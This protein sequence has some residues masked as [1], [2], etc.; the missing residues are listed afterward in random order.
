[1]EDAVTGHPSSHLR[2]L[3]R[4]ERQIRHLLSTKDDPRELLS[5]CCELLVEQ[6]RYQHAWIALV[7]GDGDRGAVPLYQHGFGHRTALLQKEL[8]AGRLVP[9]QRQ[10]LETRRV[11]LVKDCTQACAGCPLLAQSVGCA[12]IVAALRRGDDVYGWI[13][14]ALE[15]ELVIEQ[16]EVE[17]VGELAQTL[18]ERLARRSDH[19]EALAASEVRWRT[20]VEH[21][22]VGVIISDERGK[23]LEANETLAEMLGYTQAELAETTIADFPAEESRAAGRRH[24]EQVMRTG[25]ASG[26][27]ILRRKDGVKI[28][29][30]IRATRLPGRRVLAIF[31]D[32]SQQQEAQRILRI[33]RDLGAALAKATDL[34]QAL[35]LALRAAIES[36][37]MDGG[38]VYLL[39]QQQQCWRLAHAHG[40]AGQVA[41]RLQT[42]PLSSLPGQTMQAAQPTY[43]DAQKLVEVLPENAAERQ[44]GYRCIGTVPV[45]HGRQP[46]A[47]INVGSKSRTRFSE[48]A[49][50]S[51]DTIRGHLGSVIAR[52]KAGEALR[53]SEQMYRALIDQ[54]ADGV[55]VVDAQGDIATFNDQAYLMLGYTAEEFG[56]LSI[57]DLDAIDTPSFIRRRI[58][59]M[60]TADKPVRFETR[61]FTKSGEEREF[62]VSTRAV[63]LEQK[64]YLLCIMRDITEQKRAEAERLLLLKAIDQ[65]GEMV[66]ITDETG[67]IQYVNPAFV[68]ATGYP[69]DEVLGKN[70]RLLKSGKHD[71]AFYREL[72]ATLGRGE[73]WH[74][75]LINKRKD[76]T[77]FTEE[78]I[79]SPVRNESGELT[80][81][82]AAKHDVTKRLRLEEQVRQAQKMEAVGRLA[83]GVAHD[84]NNI[85]SII[86]G[87]ASLAMTDAALAPEQEKLLS[88]IV[89]AAERATRLTEQLLAFSRKQPTAPKV[90]QLSELVDSMRE[91]LER[92][93]GE[94]IALSTRHEATEAVVRVDSGQVEQILLNLAVNARD[95]M[96]NGGK[97]HIATDRALVEQACRT[98]DRADRRRRYRARAGQLRPA[99]CRGHGNRHGQSDAR[100]RLRALFHHQGGGARHRPRVGNRARYRRAKRR[101][102]RRR[103]DAGNRHL[104][105][106]SF[107]R[108]G[109]AAA[110]SRTHVTGRVHRCC[111]RDGAGGRR[112]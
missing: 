39:D 93:I 17:F 46:I 54:A 96:P 34:D 14:V 79:I 104:F 61:H 53:Q 107:S 2:Q 27:F 108:A 11:Y 102:Y 72:W 86:L 35:D 67:A 110:K 64:D 73:A 10:A 16:D 57:A 37:D 63:Q 62:H 38:A 87:S 40:S 31:R 101:A 12:N 51:L 22:P 6:A 95:A 100:A 103:I 60:L 41:E 109:S 85:L 43:F 19:Q 71:A 52:I 84:F 33:Q 13:N 24:F 15:H 92:L 91:M 83:G 78:A 88:E 3:L 82:V 4:T 25:H 59:K 89:S 18:A 21:A 9:C 5:R 44:A 97:L 45:S 99:T 66:V 80:N 94:D 49:I 29:A 47:A 8:D 111:E 26:D 74:G 76:G 32:I 42:L 30:E 65:L 70:P 75:R 28:A 68:Q 56:K 77:L 36:A 50:A 48:L 81:F 105:H 106:H 23:H 98:C 58:A 90:V 1:M 69:R 55:I 112:R 7:G 20:Y